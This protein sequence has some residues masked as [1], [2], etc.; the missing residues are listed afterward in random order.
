M[1]SHSIL[2]SLSSLIKTNKGGRIFICSDGL[3]NVGLGSL[4]DENDVSI[5]YYKKLG[6]MA[7]NNGICINLII[8]GIQKVE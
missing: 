4:K 8:F 7:K 1:F 5:K 3:A 6:E 2:I